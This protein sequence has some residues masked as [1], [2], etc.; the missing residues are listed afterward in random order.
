M[1]LEQVPMCAEKTEKMS[2][3]PVFMVRQRR[4]KEME[5]VTLLKVKRRQARSPGPR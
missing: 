1:G 3:P 2:A 5:S 4:R